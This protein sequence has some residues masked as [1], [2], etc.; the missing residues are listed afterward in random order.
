MISKD[1]LIT[2]AKIDLMSS[3][4]AKQLIGRLPMTLRTRCKMAQVQFSKQMTIFFENDIR[5]IARN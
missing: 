3:A 4:L 1:R 5:F 2:P